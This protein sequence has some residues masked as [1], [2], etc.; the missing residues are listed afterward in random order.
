MA[1]RMTRNSYKRKIIV[2]GIM[3]F[4]CIALVSTGF[5]AWII[6]TNATKEENGNIAVGKVTDGS[7]TIENVALSS[8]NFYFEPAAG[9]N[10]GRVRNS[11]GD[12]SESL[13]V[14]ITG[15]VHN[16]QYLDKLK[17]KLDLA[18]A[19]GVAEA[20]AAG[21]IVLPECAT[22]EVEITD[23]TAL[24]DTVKKFS[25]TVEFK[26]GEK[27]AGENPSI[28]FDKYYPNPNYVDDSTTPD[29][30]KFLDNKG[31]TVPDAEMKTLLETFRNTMYNGQE[32]Y[33]GAS[34]DATDMKFT[35]ILIG[36]VN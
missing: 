31:A 28:Y 32:G 23:I 34:A 13:A 30:P 1:K 16:A 36:T 20:A 5:A 17:I 22:Y 25:F 9:D 33:G 10:T 27:F 6:S 12:N 14:T 24:S 35:I 7:I 3:V 8:S 19:P 26:W 18:Q 2:I 11:E 29:E 4:V 21:F 15:E